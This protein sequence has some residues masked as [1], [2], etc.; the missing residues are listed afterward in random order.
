MDLVPI[1]INNGK[2]LM[3]INLAELVEKHIKLGDGATTCC[4]VRGTSM[5]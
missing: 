2:C 4:G 3:V 1:E 5:S